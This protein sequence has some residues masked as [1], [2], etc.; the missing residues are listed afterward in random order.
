MD[1]MHPCRDADVGE[2]CDPDGDELSGDGPSRGR[3]AG[4]DRE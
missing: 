2:C 4:R 3:V 1:A